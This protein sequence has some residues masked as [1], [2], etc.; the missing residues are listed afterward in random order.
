MDWNAVVTA[1]ANV[2]LNKPPFNIVDNLD[3]L[4]STLYV[5]CFDDDNI[6]FVNCVFEG[7]DIIPLGTS[8]LQC[9][10]GNAGAGIFEKLKG[11]IGDESFD[12]ILSRNKPGLDF[13]KRLVFADIAIDEQDIGTGSISLSGMKSILVKT[14]GGGWQK[15]NRDAAAA[16]ILSLITSL[17]EF[18]ARANTTIGK[19]ELVLIGLVNGSPS[20]FAELYS[21]F[22]VKMHDRHPDLMDIQRTKTS[23]KMDK[24]FT[25]F[26]DKTKGL[27]TPFELKA[28]SASPFAFGQ[29]SPAPAPSEPT[30]AAEAPQQEV[31]PVIRE[32]SRPAAAATSN[33]DVDQLR[34][35]ILSLSEENK[36]LQ[37][38][39]EAKEDE[40]GEV[41]INLHQEKETIE[42]E[43]DKCVA[44][45]RTEL[46]QKDLEVGEAKR[47]ETEAKAKYDNIAKVFAAHTNTIVPEKPS[48]FL[49]KLWGATKR[50]VGAGEKSIL[51]VPAHPG[52]FEQILQAYEGL[53]T[54]EEFVRQV[55][56]MMIAL[57]ASYEER[58]AAKQG[59]SEK[60]SALQRE[61]ATCKDQG[62]D[63]KSKIS[64]LQA[65]NVALQEALDKANQISP[66]ASDAEVE[67][68]AERSGKAKL[69]QELAGVKVE[70]ENASAENEA[71]KAA[72]L[73]ESVDTEVKQRLEDK[74]AE[75]ERQNALHKV[76][77][78]A[79]RKEKEDQVK[80]IAEL[81]QVVESLRGE[82]SKVREQEVYLQGELK[83]AE[84]KTATNPQMDAKLAQV[85]AE[86]S[87]CQREKAECERRIRVLDAEKT[88]VEQALGEAR[89][90]VVKLEGQTRAFAEPKA[91]VKQ[92]EELVIKQE[93]EDLYSVDQAPVVG[94]TQSL[95]AQA[96][97]QRVKDEGFPLRQQRFGDK[98]LSTPGAPECQFHPGT[99]TA[100]SAAAGTC[101]VRTINVPLTDPYGKNDT[102]F[103]AFR[104]LDHGT[105]VKLHLNR[106]VTAYSRAVTIFTGCQSAKKY[107]T[108]F[109]ALATNSQS[110][111]AEDLRRLISGAAYAH[112]R[113]TAETILEA[114]R[115]IPVNTAA[116]EYFIAPG[117]SCPASISRN[118]SRAA[119]MG[120]RQINIAMSHLTHATSIFFEH[121]NTDLGAFRYLDLIEVIIMKSVFGTRQADM[122][123]RVKYAKWALSTYRMCEYIWGEQVRRE[124]LAH[125]VDNELG[126]LQKIKEL[127]GSS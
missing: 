93:G 92:E 94:I 20:N 64:G 34:R 39:V 22:N 72:K 33:V 8:K 120:I 51:A 111:K 99:C 10:L 108:L 91:E 77:Y 127:I 53:T 71:M 114:V 86:L 90:Q 107:N 82:L 46:A 54:V 14:Y 67:L 105:Q 74:I 7:G 84:G 16:K 102:K 68:A 28:A 49:S 55:P 76:Q 29:G 81:E 112:D 96:Q 6:G 30:A 41:R 119:G 17:T 50:V 9:P 43:R 75:L 80:R 37:A 69:V 113:E 48:G 100:A 3:V 60:I 56:G 62:E 87:T 12:D 11:S 35:Q 63:L 116:S 2:E 118:K 101:D 110:A 31:K 123:G 66:T 26:A 58:N 124:R 109:D 79:D 21:I 89:R 42:Q 95:S 40:I 73:Q 24:L 104:A 70:L 18:L 103:A 57:G 15:P 38:Q 97:A 23:T 85:R 126:H 36:E 106:A 27:K 98:C 32:P 1:L 47:N 125:I 122:S 61:L 13:I 59:E 4:L 78:D 25:V 121:V 19:G 65:R 5:A 44:S 45:K 115:T 117:G 83:I 52:S 88:S